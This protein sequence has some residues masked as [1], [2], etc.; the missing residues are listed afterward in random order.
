MMITKILVVV[1]GLLAFQG[2]V[3]AEFWEDRAANKTPWSAEFPDDQVC[4]NPPIWPNNE[5][6]WIVRKGD[7][8]AYDGLRDCLQYAQKTTPVIWTVRKIRMPVRLAVG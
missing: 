2:Y 5:N 6:S 7:N 4:W 1:C 3:F 8:P